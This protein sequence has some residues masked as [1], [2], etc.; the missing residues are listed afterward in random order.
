MLPAGMASR[1]RA[2]FVHRLL[3]VGAQYVSFEAANLQLLYKQAGMPG[4][5]PTPASPLEGMDAICLDVR[6]I[7]LH[8]QGL[9]PEFA[10]CQ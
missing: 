5:Q 8:P 10:L 1:V 6:K 9:S 3:V 2:R 7:S 4:P